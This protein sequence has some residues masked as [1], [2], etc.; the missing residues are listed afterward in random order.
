MSAVGCIFRAAALVLRRSYSPATGQTLT[1]GFLGIRRGNSP[2]SFPNDGDEHCMADQR[3]RMRASAGASRSATARLPRC[4]SRA[5]RDEVLW[6]LTRQLD[7]RRGAAVGRVSGG[8]LSKGLVKRSSQEKCSPREYYEN[9]I[10]T[11][12]VIIMSLMQR[13]IAALRRRGLRVAHNAPM[14]W[15]Y[16]KTRVGAVDWTALMFQRCLG[17][18]ERSSAGSPPLLTRC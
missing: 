11:F 7:S 13:G 3:F 17:W 18:W 14:V 2:W 1:S 6:V 12:K 15:T 10:Y 16:Q 8:Y 5:R 4:S 9:S